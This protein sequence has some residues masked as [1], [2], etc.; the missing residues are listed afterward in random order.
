[1]PSTAK[2]VSLHSILSEIL[3]RQSGEIGRDDNFFHLG[4]DLIMA[5]KLASALGRKA[6][7]LMSVADAFR[8][9]TLRSLA[10]ALK[11]GE[12]ATTAITISGGNPTYSLPA[13]DDIHGFL[14]DTIA[15]KLPFTIKDVVDLP[16]TS[17][18]QLDCIRERPL[19]CFFV[20]VKG[21]VGSPAA[22]HSQIHP[23]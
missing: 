10:C 14:I 5:I 18:F 21:P 22:P 3:G 20:E 7:L 11:M 15:P 16:P 23:T 6:G 19:T 4:A 2:E 8:Q 1:M 17:P 9:P 12:M 13:L